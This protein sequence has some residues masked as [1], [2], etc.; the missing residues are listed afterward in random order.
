MKKFFAPLAIALALVLGIT[1]IVSAKDVIGGI[2]LPTVTFSPDPTKATKE[3]TTAETTTEPETSS[4][5]TSAADETSP[6]GDETSAADETSPAGDETSA[7]DETSPAGDETGAA[8]ETSPAADEPTTSGID[9]P[10]DTIITFYANGGAFAAGTGVSLDK[11]SYIYDPNVEAIPTPSRTGYTFAGWF[12]DASAGTQIDPAT[13]ELPE[14][15]YAHWTAKVYSFTV[16]ANGG[17]Y[18]SGKTAATKKV[19]FAAKVGSLGT[20]TRAGYVFQGYYTAKTGGTKI[21]AA[22][23][24]KW[25]KNLT[26][27]AQWKAATYS[28]TVNANGGKYASGKTA[29]TKKVTFAAKV[30]SLGTPTRSGYKFLGYYTAKTGGTK[31]TAANIVKWSKNLTVYAHWKQVTFTLTL[32][33][34]GGK[35]SSKTSIAKK[36][37]VGA[38]VGTLNTP[39]RSGYKFL[40]WYNAKTGGTKITATS[41]VKWSKNLTLYAHWAKK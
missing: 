38:K 29:A 21:T 5:E 32:N 13:D 7:A 10:E 36:V 25:S 14:D 8:D 22:N 30:G 15:I 35:V 3:T 37:T 6:A 26:V 18:A 16:N 1:T 11:K 2:E 40:G 9:L 27:Y 28:F 41:V 20:P 4:D 33:A 24:V 34:N 17:K 31:I 19:T 12:T 23:I 39:T